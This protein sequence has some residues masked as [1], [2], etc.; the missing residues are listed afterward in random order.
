MATVSKN[1]DLTHR[2]R[3]YI[4]SSSGI[5][6]IMAPDGEESHD[7]EVSDADLGIAYAVGRAA[8]EFFAE[9]AE[10]VG[11]TGDA[12]PFIAVGTDSRPTGPALARFVLAGLTAAVGVRTTAGSEAPGA[13][14]S[15]GRHRFDIHYVGICPSPMIMS[16]SRDDRKRVGEQSATPETG[17][18]LPVTAVP[19]GFVYITASHNPVGHNGYKIGGSDGGV[20]DGESF[21]RFSEIL[22]E[23][24]SKGAFLSR[25]QVADEPDLDDLIGGRR[26]HVRAA[27]SRYRAFVLRTLFDAE[28]PAE[29]SKA[30]E[31]VAKA[32][33][34]RPVHAVIDFNGSAR[35]VGPDVDLLRDLGVRVR[36]INDTPGKIVH[37]ILPEGVGLATC[38]AALEAEAR[39]LGN[40]HPA[41]LLGY[42]P[43]NDGDRGNLVLYDRD[44]G[45]AE[46][47]HPQTLLAIATLAEACVGGAA[48]NGRVAAGRSRVESPLVRDSPSGA[49]RPPTAVV[50]N[51]PTSLRRDRVGESLGA[52]LF[53]SEVGEANVVNLARELRESG[54]RVRI[55]GEGSNG[56][57]ILHPSGV[58]D[59]LLTLGLL[60]Q[61]LRVSR[62]IEELLGRI[63][64]FVTTQTGESRAILRLRRVNHAVLKARYE[65]LVERQWD[66]VRRS[67]F[68][69]LGITRY[70]WINYEGTRTLLGKG[71]RSTE[72]TG[73]LKLLLVD[74]DGHPRGFFWMRGSKT[75]PVFR[76]MTDIEGNDP[77]VERRLH[78]WH[79]SLLE[80][81][82]K[83]L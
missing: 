24:V 48:S 33:N 11:T 47:L 32:R 21:S 79:R 43:D 6:G 72:A 64:P 46:A 39:S 8:E 53:R 50:A 68:D 62:P 23:H 70:E 55:M 49:R 20:L 69:P 15:S 42:V 74:S 82:A 81:A 37:Q 65:E 3:D 5:R 51:G 66:E 4:V 10:S 19:V 67:L 40:E 56:G 61:A 78:D 63:P 58:R 71:N 45:R 9:R 2:F 77:A 41:T 35:T 38:R 76:L 25:E 80:K 36:T 73:G 1:V 30:A 22:R 83:G 12:M 52:A 7:P 17:V 27:D 18:T 14:G 59:P 44:T 16:Y 57:V 60:L 26:L 28:D 54:R 34:R 13:G 29:A 31:R 75:E